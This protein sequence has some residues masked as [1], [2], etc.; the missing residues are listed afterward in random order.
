MA[1]GRN[2]KRTGRGANDTGRKG[3][4]IQEILRRYGICVGL[5][6]AAA[7]VAC[8]AF[9]M[10]GVWDR[11]YAEAEAKYIAQA[12]TFMPGESSVLSGITNIMPDAG[13]PGVSDKG[14]VIGATVD[15]RKQ[16]DD[17][18]MADIFRYATTWSSSAEY[19]NSRTHMMNKYVWLED[20]DAFVNSFFPSVEDMTYHRLD[21]GLNMKFVSM[22]SYLMD[23]NDMG[24]CQYFAEVVTQSDGLYGGT[25]TGRMV[26]TYLTYPEGRASNIMCYP[27][28]PT[29]L[30]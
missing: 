5:L 15:A 11:E 9:V 8:A 6:A 14:V 1:K 16:S 19:E 4:P 21:A 20:E 27:V 29:V 10:Q 7:V 28:V 12:G 25:A 17:E 23:A 30:D 2:D 13:N 26:V 22:C 3:G 18:M 24:V